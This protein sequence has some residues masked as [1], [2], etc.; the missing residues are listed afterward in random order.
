VD[1]GSTIKPPA[2]Q[3]FSMPVIPPPGTAGNAPEVKP[4]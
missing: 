4:K 1:P 3:H 2:S